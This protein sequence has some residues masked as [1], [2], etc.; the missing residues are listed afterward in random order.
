MSLPEEI[1]LNIW[2]LSVT[3]E[4][5]V[6]PIQVREK[7]NKFLWSK[8]QRIQDPKTFGPKNSISAVPALAAVELSKVC[9]QLYA[10]IALARLFY[11][12]N[13][14]DLS[15][16]RTSAIA[17]LV[18]ITELRRDHIRSVTCEWVTYR[19]LESSYMF[20]LLASCKG[21]NKLHIVVNH[22]GFSLPS[23]GLKNLFGFKECLVA[24]QGLNVSA[25]VKNVHSLISQDELLKK[26]KAQLEEGAKIEE[27]VKQSRGLLK[28]NHEQL[29]KAML[30]ANLD[31]HGE[32]RLGEDK[33]PGLISSRTRQGLRNAKSVA[34]DGTFPVRK[35]PK[36]DMNG[37]LT[38]RTNGVEDVREV[39]AMDGTTS[40]EFLLKTVADG[41]YPFI[42]SKV[43]ESWEDISVLNLWSHMQ[44]IASFYARRPDA[45]GKQMVADIWKL[46]GIDDSDSQ[47]KWASN[48]VR[49]LEQQLKNEAATAKAKKAEE[50]AIA[51][52]EK[53]IEKAA[54]KAAKMAAKATKGSLKAVKARKGTKQSLKAKG[55]K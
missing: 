34:A 32:G 40:I 53:A 35:T 30:F 10:E 21:L 16:N 6:V 18:A 54:K 31:I 1:K 27:G 20:T 51:E 28:Y 26:L 23:N 46:R 43:S 7:S 19:R 13:V 29:G 45:S 9:K 22:A 5:P 4:E 49:R 41:G 36:Y 50:D 8:A 47:G 33:K 25:E 3:L 11:K 55:L 17:Y 38:L 15:Y 39:I 14:F 44:D 2:T 48:A 37:D 12:H 52:A 42:Y 24:I